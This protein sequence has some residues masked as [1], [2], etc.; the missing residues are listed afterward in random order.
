MFRMKRTLAAL[1]CTA[2]LL[3]PCARAEVSVS[4]HIEGDIEEIQAILNLLKESG[5]GGRAT[6]N[7]FKMRLHSSANPEAGPEADA[8]V[9]VTEEPQPAPPPPPPPPTLAFQ[10]LQVSP[11]RVAPGSM[12]AVTVNVV[13]EKNQVDTVAAILTNGT[14]KFAFDLY[15][16]G[17]HGDETAGDERWSVNVTIP[18]SADLGAY[19]L[20]LSAYTT[21]G[22][23]IMSEQDPQTPLSARTEVIVV[24]ATPAE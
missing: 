16:N 4:L 10:N 23:P 20:Q 15:D 9:T 2:L 17:T 7:P 18:T 11:V 5:I 12:T 6:F 13:D 24:Q 8:P 21:M 1:C 19:T 14:R 22:D 3:V